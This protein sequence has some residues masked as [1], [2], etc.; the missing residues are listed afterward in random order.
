MPEI[1]QDLKEKMDQKTLTLEDVLENLDLLSSIPIEQYMLP[2]LA[3][4]LGE[5]LGPCNL[6]KIL[7]EHFDVF[8]NI[9]QN[10]TS[11]RFFLSYF[12]NST[13]FEH[14]FIYALRNYYYNHDFSMETKSYEGYTA[15][16]A[17]SWMNSM[18]FKTIKKINFFSNFLEELT[19]RTL[20]RDYAIGSAISYLDIKYMKEFN[21]KTGFFKV[22]GE[23]FLENM[24]SVVASQNQNQEKK[25]VH[26]Y[27]DFCD[28]IAETLEMY[29]RVPITES[30]I[31]LKEHFQKQYP[32]L[33]LPS[34]APKELEYIFY[35]RPSA[36]TY[37]LLSNHPEYCPFLINTHLESILNENTLEFANSLSQRYE[38]F[39]AYYTSHYGNEA[40]LKL[41]TKYGELLNNDF[42]FTKEPTSK[43]E[44]ETELI[45]AV[46]NLL[47]TNSSK[48]YISLLEQNNTDFINAH[49]GMFIQLEEIPIQEEQKREKIYQSFYSRHLNY[50]YIS[51]YPELVDVLKEKDLH[52]IFGE[53]MTKT[54]MDKTS[55]YELIDILGNEEF[56][57]LCV[58]YGDYLFAIDDALDKSLVLSSPLEEVKKEIERIIAC[59]I[60]ACKITYDETQYPPFLKETNPE[61]FLS[62]SAPKEL[63]SAYYKNI[64]NFTFEFIANHPEY[65]QYL[66]GK[67]LLIPLYHAYI[68]LNKE[69]LFEFFNLFDSES[70]FKLIVQKPTTVYEMI[71]SNQVAKMY[72]WYEE[73]G[74]KFIPDY[75]VMQSFPLAEID[76]FLANGRTWS[77]IQ[78]IVR[79]SSTPENKDTL[80]KLAYTFGIF[81]GDQNGLNEL[82]NFLNGIPRH[83]SAI[84]T[85]KLYFIDS[86]CKIETD[87][88]IRRESLKRLEQEYHGF[89]ESYF[90]TCSGDGLYNYIRVK[91]AE[92]GFNID[93]SNPLIQQIY[94]E[95]P[96]KSCT[97][98]LNPE[99]SPQSVK[100][101]RI[102]FENFEIAN[103]LN[104]S[105]AHQLFG[106][107][108]LIYDKDFHKFLLDNLENILCDTNNGKQISAIQRQFRAIKTMNSNR[109]LTWELAVNFVADQIYKNIETGNEHVAE[110]SRIAGYSEEDFSTLQHIYNYSKQR[111]FSSIPR[112][113]NRANGYTYE[114]LRLDDPLALAIGTLT[115][116][117]QE[118]GNVAET[119]VEHSMVDQNGRIFV[120]RDEEG[121]IVSQSWVWRNNNVLCFDNIEVPKKAFLRATR[122]NGYKNKEEFTDE[123]FAIY[124]KAA[125]ELIAEDE[126]HYQKLLEES[127]ISKAEYEATHLRSVTVGIGYNDIAESIKRNAQVVKKVSRPLQ[128]KA[129]VP[130]NHSLWTSD[131]ITQYLLE[132]L[133]GQIISGPETL[134]IY[135]DSFNIYDK[136]NFTLKTLL[137]LQRL[138][139]TARPNAYSVN[140]QF[141]KP[142]NV[143]LY[144]SFANNYQCNPETTKVLMTP[145]F[146]IVYEEGEEQINIVDLFCNTKA[147]ND[148]IDLTDS[149]MIQMKLALI[150]ISKNKKINSS[151]LDPKGQELLSAI[152]SV[153]EKQINDKRGLNEES[154]IREYYRSISK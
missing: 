106:S 29:F 54:T 95:N 124:K 146:A 131:S 129:P 46:Y 19:D 83:I 82:K 74:H 6:Q 114:I 93:F 21:E 39:I 110:I 138:E 147:D 77:K 88:E 36:L 89:A 75:I 16:Y 34:G 126:L 42:K 47:R 80:L 61:L 44:F 116:C 139:L 4:E 125:K 132:G 23:S 117:C 62:E 115:D 27:Q 152:S 73:T 107:F 149:I 144:T 118:I 53:S 98:T 64:P 17:P 97:L 87:L 103:I 141:D 60:K 121:N 81:E 71:N 25:G 67:Y 148:T 48:N 78:N 111:I 122:A 84:H 100:L 52:I 7:R 108:A 33:F 113:E 76:K 145:N 13:D 123:I 26:S 128:F 56:L 51:E 102:L 142:N 55:S 58:E 45:E 119:C 136:E 24:Y 12:Q 63:Q 15:F 41:L 153:T 30:Y 18:N 72:T 65:H 5:A 130:L 143:D 9:T 10:V 91:L 120:V 109:N 43:E 127:L 37:K 151:S 11:L 28:I 101:I 96:D 79:Y 20:L 104:S 105:K 14:D 112:I 69:A 22:N 2:C 59:Q 49:P 50:G 38:G 68:T 99:K 92:E 94:R 134:P 66:K 154:S 86:F 40:F 137:S 85:G 31:S 135:H 57:N 140:T 3:K 133:E 150:Q 35:N 32:Y 70:A 8:T 90:M 1:P